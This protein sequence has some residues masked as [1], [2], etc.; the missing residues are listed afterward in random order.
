MIVIHEGAL[1]ATAHGLSG[2]FALRL[3]HRAPVLCSNF[4]VA[5]LSSVINL[6]HIN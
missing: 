3:Y 4:P 1:A 2:S 6:Y 5:K